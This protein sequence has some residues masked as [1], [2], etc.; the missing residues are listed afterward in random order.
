M[1]DNHLGDR[2]L[3]DVSPATAAIDLG[4]AVAA[5]TSARGGARAIA[6][7]P[8]G[9]ALHARIGAALGVSA[10]D[11]AGDPARAAIIGELTRRVVAERS[12]AP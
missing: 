4:A 2:P 9:D 3:A 12:G 10:G 5:G 11:A 7:V 6:A 8:A 1:I